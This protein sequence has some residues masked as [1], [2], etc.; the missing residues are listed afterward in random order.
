[1]LRTG[2]PGPALGGIRVQTTRPRD[3]SALMLVVGLFVVLFVVSILLGTPP[4]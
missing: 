1:M 3:F 2:R 4:R